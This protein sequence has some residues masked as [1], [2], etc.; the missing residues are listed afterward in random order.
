M[1]GVATLPYGWHYLPSNAESG[2]LDYVRSPELRPS[3][4][5]FSSYPMLSSNRCAGFPRPQSTLPGS[6]GRAAMRLPTSS[7]CSKTPRRCTSSVSPSP[8]V[9]G[10]TTSIK[11]RV[12]QPR[13]AIARPPS[14]TSHPIRPPPGSLRLPLSQ[15]ASTHSRASNAYAVSRTVVA[16]SVPRG[17]RKVNILCRATDGE[18]QSPL[19]TGTAPAAAFS[20]LPT[21]ACQQSSLSAKWFGFESSPRSACLPLAFSQAHERLATLHIAE[22]LTSEGASRSVLTC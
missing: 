5:T 17:T 3:L 16:P 19:L 2:A 12:I 22:V 15:L 11:T 14:Q 20:T 7:P 13:P 9:S 18:F 10:F 1:K 4:A 21:A 8:K 6:R